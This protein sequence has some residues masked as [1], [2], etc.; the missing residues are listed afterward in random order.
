[1][2]MG[3]GGKDERVKR[4]MKMSCSGVCTHNTSR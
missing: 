2:V 3:L 4:D 1:M